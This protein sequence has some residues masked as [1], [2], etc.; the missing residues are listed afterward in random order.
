MPTTGM[1]DW[2]PKSQLQLQ[3][4]YLQGIIGDNADVSARLGANIGYG[5]GRMFG[6]QTAQEAEQNIMKDVFSQA[7]QE[8]DPV[9]RLQTA[10][11]LFRQKGMEGR[12]Q[13]LEAQMMKQRETEAEIRYKEAQAAPKAPEDKRTNEE[14]IAATMGIL[15]G[16][17]EGLKAAGQQD[18]PVYR[19]KE[20]ELQALQNSAAGKDKSTGPE[21]MVATVTQAQVKLASG[22]PLTDA[23]RLAA[24]NTAD[25]LSKMGQFQDKDGNIVSVDKNYYRSIADS[26]RSGQQ[27]TQA[28][29]P[30]SGQQPTVSTGQSAPTGTPSVKTPYAQRTEQE[31]ADANVSLQSRLTSAENLVKDIYGLGGMTSTSKSAIANLPAALKA[32]SLGQMYGTMTGSAIKSK[33]DEWEN[34]K[35]SLLSDIAKATGLSATQLNSNFELQNWLSSLGSPSSTVESNL[36]TIDSIRNK[37]SRFT[38]NQEVM[39]QET[40]KLNPNKSRDQI[41]QGLK[42]RGL[43]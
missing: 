18:T 17:L 29:P 7:A 4:E 2:N 5:L 34:L 30:V 23:E 11:A 14:K 26:L 24:A 10:A 1:F 33:Q 42:K 9:K 15:T 43:L 13:Q 38:T 16:Q 12:A 32:S 28:Q 35:K 39:I 19:M 37:F 25:Y 22:Q 36:A 8:Q 6:G 41:I 40:M 3:Q 27:P 21:R 20:V 31:K